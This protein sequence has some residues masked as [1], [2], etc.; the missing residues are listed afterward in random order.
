MLENQKIIDL[1]SNN[2]GKI[3]FISK[4]IVYIPWLINKDNNKILVFKYDDKIRHYTES[5]V[6]YK[7]LN[8]VPNNESIDINAN[9]SQYI[10]SDNTN[11][12]Q[13]IE[14]DKWKHTF[15]QRRLYIQ[16]INNYFTFD[17]FDYPSF[18]NSKNFNFVDKNKDKLIN[19]LHEQKFWDI[20]DV[21]NPKD[22][23]FSQLQEI[24]KKIIET[25][26]K[27]I[28]NVN[29]NNGSSNLVKPP[30]RNIATRNFDGSIKLNISSDNNNNNAINRNKNIIIR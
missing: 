8:I 28:P 12:Y 7:I 15:S 3:R 24:R 26:I 20:K 27:Q 10:I 2:I 4:G 1:E 5:Q 23:F 22:E 30:D 25:F 16:S 18:V 9:F 11:T 17:N 14:D 29:E 6:E 19:I 21:I 13:I